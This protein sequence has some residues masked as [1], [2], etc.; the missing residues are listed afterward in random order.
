MLRSLVK[1]LPLL[2]LLLPWVVSPSLAQDDPTRQWFV[3]YG[4]LAQGRQL[5]A[6][7]KTY[8]SEVSTATHVTG[9]TAL[10]AKEAFQAFVRQTYGASFE[11][12]CD[13]S[14]TEAQARGQVTS[15]SSR[16]AGTVVKTG[17]TWAPAVADTA[18]QLSP[19]PKP[20]ALDH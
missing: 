6:P 3:C 5:T 14:S 1:S 15:I 17:W 13:W 20:A 4:P 10:R 9:E 18:Q 7:Q 11:P 8:L 2:A 19:P 12:R 16:T